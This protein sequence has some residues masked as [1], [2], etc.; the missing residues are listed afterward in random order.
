[1][2]PPASV[3]PLDGA[4]KLAVAATFG[5]IDD[6]FVSVPTLEPGFPDASAAWMLTV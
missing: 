4:V 5:L 3:I 6:G 1:M 2:V